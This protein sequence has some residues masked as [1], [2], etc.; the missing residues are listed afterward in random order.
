MYLCAAGSDFSEITAF[1][2][3]DGAGV[4]AEAGV[5][6]GVG[7]WANAGVKVIKAARTIRFIVLNIQGSIARKPTWRKE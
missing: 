2:V 5:G 6:D 1:G 3:G 7:V 4:G